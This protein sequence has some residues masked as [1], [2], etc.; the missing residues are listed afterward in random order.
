MVANA[1]IGMSGQVTILLLDQDGQEVYRHEGDNLAVDG[2]LLHM[3]HLLGGFASVGPVVSMRCGIG[4]TWP[5]PAGQITALVN[6]PGTSVFKT[7]GSGDIT[8]PTAATGSAK[9]LFTATWADGENNFTIFEVGLF[10]AA[11]LLIARYVVP[12]PGI[13]KQNTHTL[14]LQYLVTF[15]AV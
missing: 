13:P 6:V 5:S 7:L 1:H 3:A 4:T 14:V 11:D 9:V 12:S 8:Y 15:N 2:G 10:A